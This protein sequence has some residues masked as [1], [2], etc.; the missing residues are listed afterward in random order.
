MMYL[1]KAE[2]ED[3]QN[4]CNLE[5]VLFETKL[6]SGWEEDV[7]GKAEAQIN[8]ALHLYQSVVT[9]QVA[10]VQYKITK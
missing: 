5:A 10:A 1:R 2:A 6:E 9:Q 7:P 4:C 3:R 8:T